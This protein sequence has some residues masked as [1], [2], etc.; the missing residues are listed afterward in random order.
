[1][2]AEVRTYA[3]HGV[4]PRPVRV[5]VQLTSGRP[6]L[7]IVGLADAAVSEAKERVRG[8]L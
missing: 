4:E 1:M 3:F 5:Q 8:A 6:A 7:A 2:V